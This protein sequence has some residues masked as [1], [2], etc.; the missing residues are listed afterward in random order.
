MLINYNVVE[1]R[2]GPGHTIESAIR[3]YNGMDVPPDKLEYLVRVYTTLNGADVPRAYDS[4][5]IPILEGKDIGVIINEHPEVIEV[6]VPVI[7]TREPPKFTPEVIPEPKIE[8][9]IAE[10]PAEQIPEIPT[11]NVDE[12]D[13]SGMDAMTARQKRRE[14]ARKH[15]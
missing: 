8:I 7:K 6:P 13:F 1:H 4:V 12:Y 5:K 9:P 10:V 2:Y 15:K 11:I 14:L 3:L